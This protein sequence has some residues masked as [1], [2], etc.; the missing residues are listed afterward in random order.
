MKKFF[1]RV[2]DETLLAVAKKFGVSP[3]G[4]IAENNLKRDVSRGDVLA[5]TVTGGKLYKV[6]PTDTVESIAGKFGISPE[7]LRRKN[8]I[9]YVFYGLTI[10]V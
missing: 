1:Y 10:T 8:G 3:A 6:M 5:V 9:D 4:L 7:E 2:E